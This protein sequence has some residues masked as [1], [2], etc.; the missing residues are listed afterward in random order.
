[1]YLPK[2]FI[3]KRDDD[4]I[5]KAET[6]IGLIGGGLSLLIFGLFSVV[7]FNMEDVQAFESGIYPLLPENNA[8]SN[9]TEA[10][11]LLRQASAWMGIFLFLMTIT[12]VL[13]T[14]FI[15]KNGRP[16]I[17]GALYILTGILQLIGTQGLGFP[18]AFLFFVAAYL[19]FF[20]KYRDIETT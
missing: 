11:E 8:F 2:Y 18:I 6:I 16:K 13:A 14:V 4:L 1:M 7:I 5:R 15:Y 17:A 19:S 9:A 10:F 12:L 3:R 20:W